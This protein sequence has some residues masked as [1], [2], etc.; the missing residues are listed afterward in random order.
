MPTADKFT[1]IADDYGASGLSRTD[2]S[3]KDAWT[4]LSGFNK[5]S[6]GAPTESQLNESK[7]L[8]WKLFLLNYSCTLTASATDTFNLF[9]NA[10]I[11][12]INVDDD[13]IADGNQTPLSIADPQKRLAYQESGSKKVVNNTTNIVEAYF[14]A[15]RPRRLYNGDITDEANFVGYGSGGARSYALSQG[16]QSEVNL[17]S[18]VTDF[19]VPSNSNRIW[20]YAYVNF[21]GFHFV[22]EAGAFRG[23]SEGGFAANASLLLSSSSLVEEDQEGNLRSIQTST[24]IN[25]ASFYTLQ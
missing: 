6:V 15:S 19:K 16:G 5:N 9:P 7:R 1:F 4:T 21:E 2:V 11:S 14:G 13:I 17:T 10:V 25:F 12:G 3:G 8:A 24:Q 22:C 20:D 18:F 23:S